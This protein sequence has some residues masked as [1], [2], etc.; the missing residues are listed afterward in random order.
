MGT[1]DI[2]LKNRSTIYT[3]SDF[4]ILNWE[5]SLDAVTFFTAPL[6][7]RKKSFVK[8]VDATTLTYVVLL[9]NLTDRF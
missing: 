5:F 2:S 3:A 9:Q 4:D 6:F 1:S 8:S 7:Y